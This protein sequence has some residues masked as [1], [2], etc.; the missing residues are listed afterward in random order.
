MYRNIILIT[1][2]LFVGRVLFAQSVPSDTLLT[3]ISVLSQSYNRVAIVSDDNQYSGNLA[4]D[5]KLYFYQQGKTIL[6]EP[7]D[8]CLVVRINAILKETQSTHRYIFISKTK[9]EVQTTLQIEMLSPSQNKTIF[10]AQTQPVFTQAIQ[11][12]ISY[13]WYDK[14]F[15]SITLAGLV[16]LIYY[17]K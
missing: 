2:L 4:N 7:T 15:V 9:R 17:G 6:L 8:S 16:Y 11:K 12:N 1:I 5:L 13:H 10:L 14:Y 3:Q